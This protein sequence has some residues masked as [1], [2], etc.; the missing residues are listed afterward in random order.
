VK[1]YVLER[2]QWLARPLSR[3]FDFFS[4]AVMSLLKRGLPMTALALVRRFWSRA[5]EE[6][7]RG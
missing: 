5:M 6:Q 2:E 1:V 7:A 3:V 4:R